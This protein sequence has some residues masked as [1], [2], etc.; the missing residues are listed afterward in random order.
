[1]RAAAAYLLRATAY[2]LQMTEDWPPFALEEGE[3]VS[4]GQLPAT[5]PPAQAPAAPA[6]ETGQQQPPPPSPPP[7][8]S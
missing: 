3:G 4:A 1:M 6:P 2:F 5:P 8:G 7:A